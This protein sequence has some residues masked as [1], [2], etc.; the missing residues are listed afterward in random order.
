MPG[1]NKKTV[2]ELSRIN[3]EEVKKSSAWFDEQVKRLSS[4]KITP[5]RI[6]HESGI[7]LTSRLVPGKMYFYYYDPKFKET[8]PF[9]DQFPLVLPFAKTQ[10]GFI[11]LNMHYL[12][13]KMRMA[14]FQNLLETAGAK[15]LTETTKIRYS[16][17]TV[18][19]ASKLAPAQACVKQYLTEHVMSPFCEVPPEF[20]HTA[21]MLPVQRFVGASKETVWKESRKYR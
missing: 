18:A 16:W 5:N 15:H 21:L 1:Q 12:D 14:L 2:F 17:A 7:S 19:Q 6:M 9:Y 13:Y 20:W 4:K 11:G 10:G 8:L 3:A